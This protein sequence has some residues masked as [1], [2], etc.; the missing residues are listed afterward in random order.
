MKKFDNNEECHYDDI[1][2][3]SKLSCPLPILNTK[4]ALSKMETGKILRIISTSNIDSLNDFV[5]FAEQTGNSI[6]FKEKYIDNEIEYIVI[7]IRR[8]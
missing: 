3:V 2:D 1:L 6:V 4:K 8:R 5:I 7:Y